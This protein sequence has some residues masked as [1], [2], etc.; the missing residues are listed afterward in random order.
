[1]LFTEIPVSLNIQQ[2]LRYMGQPLN[3]Q[4]PRILEKVEK[5]AKEV[6]HL[7][8]PRAVCR[9]YPLHHEFIRQPTLGKVLHCSVA[10]S[11]IAV[12]V[13]KAIEDEIDR[14][15]KLNEPTAAL[16]ADAVGSVAVEEAAQWV[17]ALKGKQQRQRGLYATARTGPGYPGVEILQ[18]AQFL[19]WAGAEQ[20]GLCCNEYGQMMPQKSL[21]FLVGWSRQQPTLVKH[22][23]SGCPNLNC[24]F[25]EI[26]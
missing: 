19:N 8:Y 18:T 5:M 21:V 3:Q 7:L 12:T 20:I 2:V 9:D 26:T 16:T 4:S 17:L 22:K 13:G 15:F 14:L 24:Q 11:V 1:M 6:K 25:R 10:L 23:C